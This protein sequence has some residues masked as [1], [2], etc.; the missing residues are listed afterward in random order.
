[1]GLCLD[2]HG[3]ISIEVRR[4]SFVVCDENGDCEKPNP[5]YMLSDLNDMIAALEDARRYCA[6][7]GKLPDA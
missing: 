2:A 4:E 3:N 1:M 6:E 7:Q 5:E